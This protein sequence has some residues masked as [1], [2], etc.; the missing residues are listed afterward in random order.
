MSALA[1]NGPAILFYVFA[2]LAVVSALGV[3]TLRNPMYGALSL[4][5][6]FL[7]VA[8]LFILRQAEFVGMVQIFVYGGGI[9]VLFLFVIMLINLHRLPQTKLYAG[10]APLVALFALVLVAFF[11]YT[12]LRLP[13]SLPDAQPAAFVAA[14]GG[15]GDAAAGNTQAVAWNLFTQ[16]LLPF[17]IASLFLLVAMIGAVVL[18]RRQ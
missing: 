4:L 7:S 2:A 3:V 15:A 11:A 10:Q 5:V 17:E 8:V 6:T 13:F 16:S 1:A 14:G 18:G 12:F 9:M